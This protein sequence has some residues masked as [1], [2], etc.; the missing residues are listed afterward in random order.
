METPTHVALL[1][2]INVGGRNPVDM[3]ALVECF[4]AAGYGEART[5]L[6]SGNVLFTTKRSADTKLEADLERALQQRFGFAI[7]TLVRSRDEFAATIAAAPDDHGSD[8]LRSEVFF[9]KAPLTVDAVL[10][11]M[12]ELRA[13]VDSIA[14]GP[15]AIYFSRVKALAGKTRITRLMAMP[16]FQQMTVRSWRTATRLRELLDEARDER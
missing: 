14:P 16:V 6:Q 11:Q 3:G 4:H 15:G 5:H 13:G 10:D 7:P 8:Q 1:R 12:P 2:G 9:V